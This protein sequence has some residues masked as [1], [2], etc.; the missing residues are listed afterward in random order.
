MP[1][2]EENKVNEHAAKVIAFLEAA[3]EGDMKTIIKLMEEGVDVN[4]VDVMVP[5]SF[6]DYNGAGS[7]FTQFMTCTPRGVDLLITGF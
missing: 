4:A 3:D 5:L 7:H 1:S 6:F 2:K